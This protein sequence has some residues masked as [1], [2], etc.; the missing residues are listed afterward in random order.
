MGRAPL[1][2]ELV[3]DIRAFFAAVR[4]NQRGVSSL[5]G[6]TSDLD[7]VHVKRVT[8][9][10]ARKNWFKLLDEAVKGEVISID[11]N[12]SRLILKLDKRKQSIPDSKKAEHG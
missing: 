11:R 9:S 3:D 1:E 2:A 7:N 5:I 6:F 10:D 8:A 4:K 12:G